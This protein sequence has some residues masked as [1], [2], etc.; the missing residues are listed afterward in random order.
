MSEVK[1]IFKKNTVEIPDNFFIQLKQ[2]NDETEL[3]NER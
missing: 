1:E 3:A 2:Q